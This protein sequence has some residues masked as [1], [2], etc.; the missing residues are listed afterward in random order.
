MKKALCIILFVFLLAAIAGC[1]EKKTVYFD[2]ELEKEEQFLKDATSHF[3]LSLRYGT[4]E[5]DWQS[6]LSILEDGTFSGYC[7]DTDYF[8]HDM[9]YENGT[10]YTAEFSGEFANYEIKNDY[11]IVFYCYNLKTKKE[12]G[13]EWIDATSATRYIAAKP[14]G[15]AENKS[16][17]TLY[18]PE[19]PKAAIDAKI[20]SAI[21]YNTS[22]TLGVYALVNNDSGEIYTDAQQ[23]FYF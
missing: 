5:T 7:S 13:E 10:I 14:Y 18:T 6:A 3:P 23:D 11:T 20:V 1:G 19:T 15:I 17:Y 22:D 16:G 21:P 12:V 9:G 2:K 4:P 8:D